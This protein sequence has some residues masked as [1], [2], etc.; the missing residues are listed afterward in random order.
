MVGRHI[1]IGAGAGDFSGALLILREVFDQFLQLDMLVAAPHSNFFKQ[2]LGIFIFDLLRKRA[3]QLSDSVV[4]QS[5]QIADE[6]RRIVFRVLC[7]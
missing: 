3:G 4:I 5:N 7:L 2:C 1:A 6:A